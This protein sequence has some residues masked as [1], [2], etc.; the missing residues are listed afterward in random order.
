MPVGLWSI[1]AVSFCVARRSS[2]ST[3]SP[4]AFRGAGRG[5]A[6]LRGVKHGEML[7]SV[8]RVCV[9]ATCVFVYTAVCR[10]PPRA[11][12][13]AVSLVGDVASGAMSGR[14]SRGVVCVATA[15]QTQ[16][17]ESTHIATRERT[18]PVTSRARTHALMYFMRPTPIS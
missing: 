18:S 16:R 14:V 2:K 13:T 7:W 9:L 8:C 4:C 5:H 10:R 11:A 6:M 12:R 3:S 17:A 15:S 1:S